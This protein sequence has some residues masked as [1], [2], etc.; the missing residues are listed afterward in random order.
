MT[1]LLPADRLDVLVIVDNVTDSLSTNPE[2]VASEW[3]G[4]SKMGR[5][6]R[7]SGRAT[8]CA[9]HGLSLLLTAHVGNSSHTLLFDAGPEGATFVRNAEILDVDLSTVGTVVLSHGHWDHAG[10]LVAAIEEISKDRGSNVD[11]FVHPGVFAERAM[12]LSSGEYLKFEPVPQPDALAGAG[13]TVINTRE[14][15]VLGGGTFYL[16]GEIPRVT[17]YEVGFPSHVRRRED[18]QSWEPDPL[19]LDEQFLSV[20]VKNKGQVVFSAC[21]HAGIVNVL[22]Q[23]RTVLPSVPLYGAFGGFHL[24]GTTEPII[25]ETV[26]D[27][28]KFGLKML[29][30]GH[31]TGW[32]AVGAMTKAFGN[33]LV[34]S[35]VGKRYVL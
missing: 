18:G 9:H 13:A 22:T 26:S 21:S 34:P 11:C 2:C 1:G 24:S 12:K 4:L 33:T 27:L 30:P 23:A 17:S 19:I 29:A 16:S 20:H 8:C 14:P 3:I 25:P 10:G 15:Q 32:R 7:L 28:Q 31:C 6:P 5:L 35:A